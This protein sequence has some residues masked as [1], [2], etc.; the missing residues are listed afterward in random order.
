MQRSGCV[1]RPG[2][3]FLPGTAAKPF[4]FKWKQFD[5]MEFSRQPGKTDVTMPRIVRGF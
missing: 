3:F 2:R 4:I 5:G 1:A